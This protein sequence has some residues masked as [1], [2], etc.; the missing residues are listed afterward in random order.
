MVGS[1]VREEDSIM[2][3]K[4]R[5]LDSRISS[6]K[7]KLEILLEKRN[8]WEKKLKEIREEKRKKRDWGLGW[9]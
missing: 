6:I 2:K 4:I 8:F 3:D 1:R 5:S 9:K 7:N